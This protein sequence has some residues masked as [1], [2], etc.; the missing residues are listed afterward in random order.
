MDIAY[1]AHPI[2]GHVHTNLLRIQKIVREINLNEPDVVPFVPYY[3]DCTC[4]K[5]N[6]YEERKR[7]IKNNM[8]LL[9]VPGLV[10]ELRLYGNTISN[11]MKEEIKYCLLQG[12]PVKPM[13]RETK[14][15]Y[16]SYQN[17]WT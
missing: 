5:D 16:E 10:T 14:K 15:L 6:D 11:G 1:I 9:A 12:I 2:S 4:M 3:V 8:A 17:Q 13:T 7:G